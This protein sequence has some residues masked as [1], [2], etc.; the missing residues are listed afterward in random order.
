MLALVILACLVG[1]FAMGRSLARANE[2]GMRDE[3]DP[4][5]TSR[6]STPCLDFHSVEEA[7]RRSN[8]GP[9]GYLVSE[10]R[11]EHESRRLIAEIE[12][13]LAKRESS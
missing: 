13:F 12:Q 8:F 5:H 3:D 2:A 7:R 6:P 11:I 10:R 1:F 9:P 4:R